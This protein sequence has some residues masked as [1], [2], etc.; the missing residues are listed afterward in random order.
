MRLAA[1]TVA[2]VVVGLAGCTGSLP[3]SGPATVTPGPAHVDLHVQNT[4]Q[5]PIYTDV[6][7][8]ANGTDVEKG[9]WLLM[10]GQTAEF[11]WWADAAQ[12]SQMDVHFGLTPLAESWTVHEDLHGD[13]PGA[14]SVAVNVAYVSQPPATGW[15]DGFSC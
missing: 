10:A 11:T 12:P 14:T 5:Y 13:C 6:Y 8:V 2:L 3:A 1:A 15:K 7:A 4:A 9:A